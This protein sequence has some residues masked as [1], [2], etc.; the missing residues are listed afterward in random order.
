MAFLGI[1]TNKQ[2]LQG[3]TC[4][5]RGFNNIVFPDKEK[6]DQIYLVLF[7]SEILFVTAEERGEVR[8]VIFRS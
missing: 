1:V 2:L 6:P 5:K 4:G 8:H 3:G 7:L